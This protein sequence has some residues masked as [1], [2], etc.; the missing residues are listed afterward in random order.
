MQHARSAHYLAS[1]GRSLS[2]FPGL[3]WKAAVACPQAYVI[4]SPP[5]F[6][7]ALNVSEVRPCCAGDQI[8]VSLPEGTRV[9]LP[10]GY[11]E[12]APGPNP[13]FCARQIYV[14]ASSPVAPPVQLRLDLS[15]PTCLEPMHAG[16]PI[17][18]HALLAAALSHE[19]VQLMQTRQ[20]LPVW[21]SCHKSL[22]GQYNSSMLID[23]AERAL[24]HRLQAWASTAVAVP[25]QEDNCHLMWRC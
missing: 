17:Q 25:M 22:P 18:S 20:L 24:L 1:R 2:A 7:E 23:E 11:T 5:G 13:A 6:L 3:C 9:D 12:L 10:E 21:R 15:D 14:E 19:S 8:G 4:R 16:I